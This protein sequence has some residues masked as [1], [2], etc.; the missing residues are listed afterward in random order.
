MKQSD[1]LYD[2]I[3]SLTGNEKRFFKIYAS[4]H[5]TSGKNNYVRLFE[6]IDKL[7]VYDDKKLKS[8]L[9]I[10]SS[11]SNFS[12]EKNYLYN[13]IL[14]CLDIY[15]KDSSVDRLIN[16]YMNIARILSEK[17]LD[18]QSLT[19]IKKAE[20]ISEKYNRFENIITLTVLKKNI[21][22][23]NDSITLADP[24]TYYNE[25]FKN[26]NKLK[27]KVEY[28]K[29]R[30]ALLFRRKQSGPVKNTDDV[31]ELNTFNLTPYFRDFT[32]V[33]SQDANIFYLL[34]KLEYYRILRDARKCR[35]YCLK[36]ISIFDQHPYRIT[37]HMNLLI[38][39]LTVF[40]VERL[41]KTK[42][43]AEQ[44]LKKIKALPGLF[45]KK[46]LKIDLEV[47][48]FE[49]YCTCITDIALQFRDYESALPSISET[50]KGL[51]KF[52]NSISPIF[53]LV[54]RS[55]VACIYFGVKR[56]KESLKWCNDIL[57]DHT[58]HRDDILYVVHIL[59]LLN[60]F[61]L[62]NHVILPNLMKAAYR[63]FY[64]KKRAYQF[65]NLFFKYL[66]L[67]LRSETK[68]EQKQ[69]FISFREEL[70]PLRE[71]KLENLIFNDIDII[72]WIDHKLE[73]Q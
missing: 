15:H 50:E 39:T 36:L 41:Y 62:K 43:E 32:R 66:T 54:A 70:I 2:L 48:I 1:V 60:H 22:F 8:Q 7:T 56:Y 67:F 30:D 45:G 53:K 61:E 19:I 29:V 46:T 24:D 10:V 57:N 16:K 27:T 42:D 6:A 64:K 12:V 71:N 28:T 59:Y 51:K 58:E 17:R 63:F 5:V 18:K 13:L 65:E 35:T 23:V 20:A 14:E 3:K 40:I 33:D 44:A 31:L 68:K 4:R 34:A 25:L 69:L 9:K 52:Q 37:D 38:Y 72:G 11:G 49:V 55:N 73:N 21:G 47:K 26:I